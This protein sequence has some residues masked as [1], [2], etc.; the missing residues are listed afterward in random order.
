MVKEGTK[1]GRKEGRKDGRRPERAAC[2]FAGGRKA[3]KE[4]EDGKEV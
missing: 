2:L 1:E 4:V 3:V